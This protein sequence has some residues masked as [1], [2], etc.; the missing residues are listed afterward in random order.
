MSPTVIVTAELRNWTLDESNNVIWG[1]IFDDVKER[2]PDGRM[3]HTSYILMMV[4]HGE[5]YLI[6]T[7]N[8]VYKCVKTTRRQ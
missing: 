1:E 8:S 3:I 4:D 6:K 7:F 5:Y 2:W